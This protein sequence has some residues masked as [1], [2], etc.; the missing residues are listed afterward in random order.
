MNLLC[1]VV[2]TFIVFYR[3]ILLPP[4]LPT[5]EFEVFISIVGFIGWYCKCAML[6]FIFLSP[7]ELISS[8]LHFNR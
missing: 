7:L 3:N 2:K 1:H 8:L 5:L 6:T 4:V